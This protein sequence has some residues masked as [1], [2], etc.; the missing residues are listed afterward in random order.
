MRSAAIDEL[1]PGDIA[2]AGVPWDERSSFLRG[3]ALGPAHVRASLVSASSNLCTES[4]RD[5]SAERALADVGDLAIDAGPAAIDAIDRGAA[6][7]LARGAR[8]VAIG[9]DHAITYPLVRAH[10]RVHGPLTILHLDAHPDLYEVFEGDPY[11]HACPFARIMEAGLATA[12]VQVGIR[13]MTP[14]QRGQAERFG[15]RVVEMRDWSPTLSVALT[16]P[17][18]LSLDLDVLDPAF[19]P[20]VSH[21]EPGGLSVRDV[22]ALVQRVE[23]HL[24]GADIV[25][26]NPT[27]DVNDVTG[28][29]A[30]KLA[31]EI[32]DRM[33]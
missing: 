5:L 3:A 24:V 13:T 23:G 21:H 11:S 25:E 1:G 9:G 12:L 29:V 32:V 33:L 15:V 26:C 30:A 7:V 18:Y 4:G 10:A 31:K 28:M 8:L 16:G 14:H 19:A 22:I 17:V 20:G 2:L 6:A 27:R